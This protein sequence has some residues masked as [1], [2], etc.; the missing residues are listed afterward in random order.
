MLLISFQPCIHR[1]YNITLRLCYIYF[2]RLLYK[3]S[4]E[5]STPRT[6][7][8]CQKAH[9]M[10]NQITFM[11]TIRLGMKR[12][13]IHLLHAIRQSTTPYHHRLRKIQLANSARRKI[14]AP[15]AAPTCVKWRWVNDGFTVRVWNYVEHISRAACPPPPP[16]GHMALRKLR[17][18]KLLQT[19]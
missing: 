8:S 13:P 2:T 15:Y 14:T 11:S 1:Y 12:T 7:S 17:S 5:H 4:P 6:F 3:I 18:S 16:T 19:N 9:Y 10:N